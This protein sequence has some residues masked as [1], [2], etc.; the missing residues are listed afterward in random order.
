MKLATCASSTG[1][2]AFVA[3]TAATPSATAV[4]SLPLSGGGL[5]E[6]EENADEGNVHA[7]LIQMVT[8]SS[9]TPRVVHFGEE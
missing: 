2:G 9:M 7:T 1:V 3:G 6:M 8:R 4:T 5:G